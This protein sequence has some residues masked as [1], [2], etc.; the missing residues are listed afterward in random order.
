MTKDRTLGRPEPDL[1]SFAAEEAAFT[2]S[3]YHED[4]VQLLGTLNVYLPTYRERLSNESY[5]L[6]RDNLQVLTECFYNEP[7]IP[8]AVEVI[9]LHLEMISRTLAFKLN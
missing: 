2:R 4:V 9:Y 6:I 5:A 8:E 3:P 7:L 1:P